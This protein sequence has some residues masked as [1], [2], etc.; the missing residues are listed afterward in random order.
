MSFLLAIFVVVAFAATIEG[1]GLPRRVR[2]VVRRAGDCLT[3]LRDSSLDDG[4]KERALQRQ[5]VRLFGLLGILAGGS[6]L[7]LLLPLVGVW[8][9]EALGVASLDRVLSVLE[10]LDFLAGVT[11]V[12]VGAY[13]LLRRRT[14]P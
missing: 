2:E 7:A 6:L 14:R 12:G 10:R 3:V 8:L 5:A 1:L 4:A 9:L 11:V 13:V